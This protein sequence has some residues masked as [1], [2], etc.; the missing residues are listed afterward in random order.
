MEWRNIESAPTDR[1]FYV[2]MP[3]WCGRGPLVL[4]GRRWG[5]W[6]NE[7]LNG[8]ASPGFDPKWWADIPDPP[9]SP[10]NEEGKR[11]GKE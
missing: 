11:I 3:N 2:W 6:E 8:C 7:L 1:P 9:L 4:T 5:Y 10:L